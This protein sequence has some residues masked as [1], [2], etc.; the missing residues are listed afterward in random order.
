VL[1][2][3]RERVAELK[4]KGKPGRHNMKVHG[5]FNHAG[6]SLYNGTNR[7]H[8]EIPEVPIGCVFQNRGEAAVLGVHSLTNPGIDVFRGKPCYAV[9]LSGAYSDDE[10]NQNDRTIIYTG[11]GG[12]GGEDETPGQVKDQAHNHW[13]ASV[14]LAH[15]KKTPIRVLRGR[16]P[17]YLYEGLF[18]CAHYYYEPSKDGP[19]VFKFVL[20]PIPGKITNLPYRVIAGEKAIDHETKRRVKQH[21]KRSTTAGRGLGDEARNRLNKKMKIIRSVSDTATFKK[22]EITCAGSKPNL[23]GRRKDREQISKLATNAFVRKIQI[24]LVKRIGSLT[25]LTEDFDERT[26]IIRQQKKYWRQQYASATS[27]GDSTN[28]VDFAAIWGQA[29]GY[30]VKTMQEKFESGS[31]SSGN[32]NLLASAE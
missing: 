9:C 21:R 32:E 8:G 12:R 25:S 13:N 7:I 6:R 17:F 30:L 11:A 2:Q 3:F 23:L 15:Q 4:L 1:K 14:I 31:E 24:D 26:K 10:V 28:D 20:K 18:I 29:K 5:E 19:K 16:C 22:P 27:T